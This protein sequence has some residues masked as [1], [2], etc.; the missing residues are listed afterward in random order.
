MDQDIWV[1][2]ETL[3]GEVLEISYTM[4][5]AGRE[6]ADGLG[7]SVS[8]L[9]LGHKAGD[10]AG[11][12]GAADRVI[13]VDHDGRE[14]KALIEVMPDFPDVIR[15]RPRAGKQQWLDRLEEHEIPVAQIMAGRRQA[16]RGRVNE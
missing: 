9:L 14:P 3:R 4:L 1:L 6:M 5:A 13:N 7:G 15:G 16:L 11:Q 10:L 12:L 8:A 2:V